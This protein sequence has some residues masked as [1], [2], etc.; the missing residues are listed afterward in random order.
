MDTHIEGYSLSEGQSQQREPK[1][2]SRRRFWLK[3]LAFLIIPALFRAP[4]FELPVLGSDQALSSGDLMGS[5]VVVNFWASWC[6]PGRE[7]APTLEQKRRRYPDQ[8]IRFVGVNVQDVE[9]DATGFV[10]EFGI[11]FPSV[12]DTDLQLWT[13]FGVRGLPE[14]FFIDHR[15]RFVSV[16]SGEQSEAGARP[17]SWAP[18]RPRCW[19]VRS[20]FFSKRKKNE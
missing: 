20:S 9:E 18:S 14:T 8:G 5:P 12:R 17:R 13:Q 10:E 7:E 11:T 3:Q 2:N 15:W 1:P 4:D 16:G 6:V 19:K